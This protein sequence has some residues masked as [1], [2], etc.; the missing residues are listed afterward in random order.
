M[1]GN[2]E[3]FK[4]NVDFYSVGYGDYALKPWEEKI[5]S[6]VKGES[7]LDVACGG[8][9]MTVPLLRN[10]H[11]VI[12]MDFVSE[13]KPKIIEHENEFKGKFEFVESDMVDRFPFDDNSF[14]ALTC[15]NSIVYL[16]DRKQ[17][18]YVLK[19]M[20]RVL[21]PKGQLF[22]TSWNIFHPR[23][24]TSL[25][26]NYLTRR[27]KSFGQTSPFFPT[28]NRMAHSKTYM[29]VPNRWLLRKLL[30]EL[31]IDG[32]VCTSGEYIGMKGIHRLTTPNIVITGV[33]C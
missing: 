22:I 6:Q 28:D 8:G 31:N 17:V 29:Y 14:D 13:F 27:G 5:L 2:I 32:Q 16:K 19:E 30:K 24:G 15:I 3:L 26:L 1:N 9:R 11:N 10:G 25:V 18:E 20:H 4:N 7:V 12:G 33:K 21:K 23:W